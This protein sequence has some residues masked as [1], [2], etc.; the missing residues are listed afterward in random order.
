MEN[1]GDWKLQ[2]AALKLFMLICFPLMAV[3]LAAWGY[4]YVNAGRH[5]PMEDGGS[6]LYRDDEAR[7][8]T[9]A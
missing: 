7:Y 2:W 1:L 3:V 9:G 5:R 6:E 4:T 8:D